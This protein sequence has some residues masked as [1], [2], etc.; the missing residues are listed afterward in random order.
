MPLNTKY[1]FRTSKVMHTIGNVSHSIQ[2]IPPGGTSWPVGDGMA[3]TLV[4]A[5]DWSQ[6]PL[7]PARQWQQGLKVAVDLVLACQFPMIVLWGPDLAQIYNDGYREIMGERHPGGMGQATRACWPEVWHINQPIYARVLRGEAVTFEDQLYPIT[8]HGYLEDAYFTLCYSPL[9]DETGGVEGVL[10]TVFETTERMKAAAE[11]RESEARLKEVFRQAPAF[12][13]MLRGPEHVFEMVNPRYQHLI[14]SRDVLGKPLRECLPEAEEQG[15]AD[16]LD[17]VYRTGEPFVAKGARFSVALTFGQAKEDRYLDF[18]YQPLREADGTVSGVIVLGV[19]V[20]EGK[21]A[22]EALAASE[23]ELR[24]TVELNPHMPWTADPEGRI[25]EFSPHWLEMTGLTR[26]QALGQ[27]WMQA[28]HP[29]DLSLMQ[30]RWSHSLES[31]EPYDIEHR[32]RLATGNHRWMRSRAFPRRD[33]EGKIVRWYGS[34]EDIHDRKMAESALVQSEKLATVG[35]LASSIAHEINNPLEAVTNLLYLARTS[36]H[37]NQEVLEC[38]LAAESEL[39]RV[40]LIANQTLRFH[41]QSTRQQSVRCVELIGDALSIYKGRLAG[42]GIR[43]E[44]RKRAAKT[45]CC[46]EGEIRQVLNNLIGNAIDAISPDEGRLLLRSREATDWKS[47]E[48]G[49]VLT[50]ADNGIGMSDQTRVRIFDPFFTT[51]VQTGIG[52]GLWVSREIVKRHR[53]E[54]RVR[55]TQRVGRSG[56]VFTLFLPFDSQPTPMSRVSVAA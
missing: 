43:V 8:R 48:K 39:A 41:K 28:P 25:L 24:W 32:V 1:L 42:T 23:A 13:V 31:G 20:T 22:A 40:A 2:N 37:V 19:D 35:R 55:S 44:K 47:G 27:G 29:E 36:Q 53:G 18:V 11:L 17:N 6:T 15:F 30:A 7:G 51:K 34:T 16:I 46:F 5:L 49:L 54:L 14:G 9:R 56:T 33:A 10:V 52:L 21:L 4:R 38:L 26:R 50:V 12:V 45:V 3:A